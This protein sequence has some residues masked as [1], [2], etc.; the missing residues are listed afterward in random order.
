MKLPFNRVS[1]PPIEGII[2]A[3]YSVVESCVTPCIAY[4]YKAFDYIE[5]VPMIKTL[6]KKDMQLLSLKCESS[7]SAHFEFL[8]YRNV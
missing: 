3:L 1:C 6:S 8:V 4:S 7:F 2:K 5:E